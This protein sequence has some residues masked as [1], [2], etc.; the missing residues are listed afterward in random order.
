MLIP[1]VRNNYK[2]PGLY[3]MTPHLFWRAKRLRAAIDAAGVGLWSWNVDTDEIELDQRA[4]DL[5]GHSPSS[6]VT[7]EDLSSHIHPEDRDKVRATFASTRPI[8]G[9][10]ELDFR[11]M[12]DNEIRWVSARGQGEGRGKTARILFGV[13]LDVTQRKQAAEANELLAGE[14]SHRVSN[15]L[16]IAA[17]LTRMAAKSAATTEDMAR[18]LGARLVALGRAHHLVRPTATGV[19]GTALIGDLFAVLLQPYEL[20]QDVESGAQRVRISL[21]RVGLVERSITSLALV[22]HEL[23]T[24]S[25]KHG[26]LSSETGTLDVSAVTQ[27]DDDKLT[28]LWVERGGPA[29]VAPNARS[30]FGRGMI[31]RAV[32]E[33]LGGSIAFDW[34]QEG[35]IA[36]LRIDMNCLAR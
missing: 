1:F 11:I 16:Q 12:L 5:W 35:V 19:M 7:F 20:D 8:L 30:G 23:A 36:T 15:L 14:M 25:L 24:N 10:F 28:I 34:S 9:T 3:F 27:A 31:A 13:F 4:F 29:V 22:V 33:D 17:G 26:A 21:P 32:S 2:Y 6:H 18:D